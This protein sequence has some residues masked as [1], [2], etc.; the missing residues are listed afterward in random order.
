MPPKQ[1]KG[2][3]MVKSTTMTQGEKK[4]LKQANKA[5]A[6]PGKASDKKAKNDDKRARRAESGSTKSF[7]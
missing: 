2:K 3:E 4:K 1:T 7:G 5:K 6:N